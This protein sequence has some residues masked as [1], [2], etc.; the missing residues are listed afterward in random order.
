[1]TTEFQGFSNESFSF[2][3]GLGKDNSKKY[4]D[5]NRSIYE[6][7]LVKPA[8]AFVNSIAPFLEQLDPH[9]R[10]EPKFNQTIMRLNNDMR[11]SKGN[12]Y[13]TYLLLHF[14]KFKLDSE[15]YVF[16]HTEGIGVGLFLNSEKGENFYLPNNLK[17]DSLGFK[18]LFHK[19]Q[20]DKK[21][22]LFELKKNPVRLSKI[23]SIKKDYDLFISKKWILLEKHFLCQTS[24]VFLQIY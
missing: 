4:F 17:I 3:Q 15:F 14:G 7:Y 2:L 9:L 5:S 24:S 23:F 13:R 12:P 19:Y 21:F 10:R 11:F 8:K 22:S 20:L 6:E 18:E 16:I 1:M